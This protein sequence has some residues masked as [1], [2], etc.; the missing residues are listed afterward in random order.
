M[1][2]TAFSPNGDGSNDAFM[3]EC[4]DVKSF[5]GQIYSRQGQLVYEW[6]SANGHWDGRDMQGNIM[7]AGVYFFVIEII[8]N[9]GFD[10]KPMK[11]VCDENRNRK[12]EQ[13]YP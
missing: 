8:G 7:P 9:D 3:L 5:H 2:P 6:N 4:E 12:T 13:K 10:R 11:G 1:R